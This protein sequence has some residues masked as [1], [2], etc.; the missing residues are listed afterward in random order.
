MRKKLHGVEGKFLPAGGAVLGTPS[1]AKFAH[2]D[3]DDYYNEIAHSP[4]QKKKHKIFYA[5]ERGRWVEGCSTSQPQ[6]VVLFRWCIFL[7]FYY[8]ILFRPSYELMHCVLVTLALT[9]SPLKPPAAGYPCGLPSRQPL[10][11]SRPTGV[12]LLRFGS[13]LGRPD[14][15]RRNY[16]LPARVAQHGRSRRRHRW[17][18]GAGRGWV[19]G[20]V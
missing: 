1:L 4:R 6:A 3:D 17:L 9:A 20:Q 7:F 8:S 19:V 15:Y 11:L 16:R 18:L 14:R 5:N 13:A 12:V 2:G 10:Q